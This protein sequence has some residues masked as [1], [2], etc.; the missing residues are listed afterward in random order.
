MTVTAGSHGPH[1]AIESL[2]VVLRR[3]GDVWEEVLLGE[4]GVHRTELLPGLEARVGE[5][6][7]PPVEVDED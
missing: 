1:G 2:D 7:G 3:A 6:L 4:D 5:L